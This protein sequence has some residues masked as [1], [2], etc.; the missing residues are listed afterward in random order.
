MQYVTLVNRSHKTLR[1]I[2]DGRHYKIAPGPSS[3]PEVQAVKFK[4]QNPLMG[5][6]NPYTLEKQYLIGIVEQGDDVTPLEQSESLEL[7][8]GK[9]LHK[10][11]TMEVV[12]ANGI[13]SPRV[14][15][16]RPLPSDGPFIGRD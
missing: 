12:R 1:G 10:G 5:S 14:D 13:Y 6:E 9:E 15:A 3:F 11:K 8:D 2:W 16:A 7:A 4:E